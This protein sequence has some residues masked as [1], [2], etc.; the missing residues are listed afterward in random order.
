MLTKADLETLIECLNE[1]DANGL[2]GLT[3]VQVEK[4]RKKLNAA[5]LVAKK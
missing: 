4:L 5:I 2:I 3:D 1:V